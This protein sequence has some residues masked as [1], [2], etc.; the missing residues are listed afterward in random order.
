MPADCSA[1]LP[2]PSQRVVVLRHGER[3]D[4]APDAPPESDPPLTEAGVDAVQTA[5]ARLKHYLGAAAAHSAVLVVSPFLRTLQTAECLQHHGV[6]AAH[7]MVIDNTLC[8]VF[9]PSR[10]KTTRAPQL[11]APLMSRAVGG[12][13]IWGESMEAATERYVANFLRN[14]DVYGGHL[15]ITNSSTDR[16]ALQGDE[17][18][19]S[20]SL[21]VPAAMTNRCTGRLPPRTVPPRVD[22]ARRGSDSTSIAEAPPQ[23][24]ILVTHGDAIS[25]V[26]AHFYPAR[27]VYEADFLSFVIMR[28]Y[29]VGNQVYHLDESAGVNWLVEG[30]DREPQDSILSAMEKQRFAVEGRGSG[31]SEWE[32]GDGDG[33]SCDNIDDEGDNLDDD[34][35]TGVPVSFAGRRM[36]PR[37][38]GDSTDNSRLRRSAHSVSHGGAATV[39]P[40]YAANPFTPQTIAPHRRVARAAS[41]AAAVE[42]DGQCGTPATVSKKEPPASS[43]PPSSPT[44]RGHHRHHRITATPPRHSSNGH[45]TTAAAGAATASSPTST[46]AS[47]SPAQN[48][49]NACEDCERIRPP[50]GTPAQSSSH[51]VTIIHHGR[52]SSE[53]EDTAATA[54]RRSPRPQPR[55]GWQPPD[56]AGAAVA[57]QG[58]LEEREAEKHVALDGSGLES[59]GRLMSGY[60]GLSEA[61]CAPSWTRSQATSLV[62]LSTTSAGRVA[63]PPLAQ[64]TAT[65]A[66]PGVILSYGSAAVTP[67]GKVVEMDFAV[68]ASFSH[69][70]SASVAPPP[71]AIAAASTTELTFAATDSLHSSFAILDRRL[72]RQRSLIRAVSVSFALRVATAVL[73]LLDAVTLR[74]RSIT[75]PC[76]VVVLAWEVGFAVLLHLSCRP[77]VSRQ[78]RIRAAVEQLRLDVTYRRRAA[79]AH[80]QPHV[81]VH[82]TDDGLSGES[83]P[84]PGGNSDGDGRGYESAVLWR[85]SPSTADE[86]V[87][88]TGDDRGTIGEA[89]RC[90][91][92]HAAATVL[93]LLVIS[94]F[95]VAFAL[96]SGARATSVLSGVRD[97]FVPVAGLLFVLAH[98]GLNI[99][100]G[101]WDERK[102]DRILDHT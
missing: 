24:V 21:V 75:F 35:D 87:S 64:A 3:R 51:S 94:A 43:A 101:L 18:H 8:E 5:A 52:T 73:L 79:S 69:G 16:S 45:T 63:T 12:L 22:P 25:A 100:R 2:Y 6:G 61:S 84:H 91:A 55:D 82:N 4:S 40:V 98:A 26:V 11:T 93:K 62:Y 19:S 54:E 78:R 7:T 23:D 85:G 14:G 10:I 102:L 28:R 53:N 17:S 37:R 97:M 50:T 9:G 57:L 46:A 49:P 48:H 39:P 36:R 66:A 44:P 68:S 27:V 29:G 32:N 83:P 15:A 13:P 96:L 41:A 1:G 38:S 95:C 20:H 86:E 59:N 90:A 89:L 72:D 81:V 42:S 70:E 56:V 47:S 92:R 34:G 76:I 60:G 33:D 31:D 30:I 80:P 67:P 58:S 71:G 77:G 88:T 65:A 74:H 99:L